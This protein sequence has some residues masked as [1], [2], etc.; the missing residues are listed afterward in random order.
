VSG[1]ILS[2]VLRAVRLPGAWAETTL[3][4]TATV[5]EAAPMLRRCAAGSDFTYAWLDLASPRGA[6]GRGLVADI[7]FGGAPADITPDS[8]RFPPGRVTAKSQALLPVPLLFGRPGFHEA[9]V[10]VP[11]DAI[12]AYVAAPRTHSLRFGAPIALCGGK[13][14]AGQPAGC[15]STATA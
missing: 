14:F 6:F 12:D 7:R 8:D 10:I 13:L 2:A 11:H 15:A 5:P 4:R 3:H 9:Q 1:I